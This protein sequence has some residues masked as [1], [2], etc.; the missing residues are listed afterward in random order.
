MKFIPILYSIPMVQALLDD[1]KFV[2]RR[3]K[4]LEVIN[5]NPSLFRYDGVN[6]SDW[7]SD[8]IEIDKSIF[9]FEHLDNN[10]KYL[11]KYEPIKCPYGNVG[12]VLWVRETYYAYG[13]WEKNGKTK[14]GKQKWVF[15]DLT[16]WNKNMPD[17]GYKY[18]DNPPSN[19]KK[20][21]SIVEG[22]YKRPSLFMPKAACRIFLQITD[23]RV[24]RLQGITNEDS[25]KEGIEIGETVK[26]PLSGNNLHTY[27]NYVTNEFKWFNPKLSF[28]TLWQSINGKESWD[29]NPWVW[30]IVFERIEKPT[31]LK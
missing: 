11:E 24:E 30:V 10:G 18:A 17:G 16:F 23:I 4:G 20:G 9:W 25:L 1:R 2:T 6:Q 28:N 26:C 7:C 27:K 5:K 8:D 21:K 31:D 22:Y 12:N 14:T 19:F 13:K 29:A 3:T 15:K